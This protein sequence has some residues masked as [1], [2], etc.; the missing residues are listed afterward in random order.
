MPA[1]VQ[2]ESPD[3]DLYSIRRQILV[4]SMLSLAQRIDGVTQ[5]HAPFL[6]LGIDIVRN[7]VI[8]I[9]RQLIHQ[10]SLDLFSE[11]MYW[12][13]GYGLTNSMSMVFCRP[14]SAKLLIYILVA[15]F[16]ASAKAPASDIFP[17]RVK[18]DFKAPVPA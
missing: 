10:A 2:V 16:R 6:K 3:P 11:V 1:T 8:Q 5:R 15:L 14:L 17:W 4:G 13:L 9:N 18:E 12:M 7:W